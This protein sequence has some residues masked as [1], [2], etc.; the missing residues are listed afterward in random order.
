MKI[1]LIGKAGSGKSTVAQ[2]LHEKYNLNKYSLGDG[3]KQITIDVLNLCGINVNINDLYDITKKKQYRHY[4]QQIGTDICKKYF[5]KE[6]W[7]NLLKNKIDQDQSKN[8]V[9]DDIRFITEY[10]YWYDNNTISIKLIRN[11]AYLEQSHSTESMHSSETEMDKIKCDYTID[12]NGS[13]LNVLYQKI[14][15]ILNE[16]NINVN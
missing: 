13:D 7:C 4:M 12:N 9:I 10:N 15:E 3:V 1:L 16:N 14:D 2:Y 5:G 6:C 11:N 8:Y